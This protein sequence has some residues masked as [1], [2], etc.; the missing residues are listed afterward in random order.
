[1]TN[2]EECNHENSFGVQ[3]NIS[4]CRY[5][6][7]DYGTDISSSIGVSRATLYRYVSLHEMQILKADLI[8]SCRCKRHGDINDSFPSNQYERWWR[9]PAY[10]TQC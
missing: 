8:S 4:E 2:L 3:A 7:R 10:L 9:E 6:Y 5:R 1:M